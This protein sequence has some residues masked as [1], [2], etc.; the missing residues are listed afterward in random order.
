MTALTLNAT[1][2]NKALVEFASGSV[3]SFGRS[4]TL[5]SG[6]KFSEGDE[7]KF[8]LPEGDGGK[9][10]IVEGNLVYTAPKYF[11]IKVK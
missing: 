2:E 3:K 5:T 9:L 4:Y 6:G 7:A 11:I 1:A 8:A 10:T